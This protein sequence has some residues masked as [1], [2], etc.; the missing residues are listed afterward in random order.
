MKTKWIAGLMIAGLCGTILV[1]APALAGKKE[2]ATAGKILTGVMAVQLLS[3]CGS[4]YERETVV[5]HK[6][7]TV[8]R[9][10]SRR[11]TRYRHDRAR[12]YRSPCRPTRTGGHRSNLVVINQGPD[13][14]VCQPRIHGHPAFVQVWSECD[15][16][17]INIREHPSI[18]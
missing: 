7:P 6:Q 13:R 12:S 5:V 10:A 3:N 15:N 1:P 11:P 16:E 4:R 18:W 14:R 17:W 9:Y 2:W 8:I